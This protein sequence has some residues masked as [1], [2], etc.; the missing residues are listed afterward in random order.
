M[1]WDIFLLKQI[2]YKIQDFKGWEHS[3]VRGI[4]S[5]RSMY[6]CSMDV[7][8][9]G[10]DIEDKNEIHTYYGLLDTVT[11]LRLKWNGLVFPGG[12]SPRYVSDHNCE[13]EDM[14]NAPGLY[15]P[16]FLLKQ[17]W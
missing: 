9:Y 13:K 5:D 15:Y 1:C 14:H 11:V 2:L 6:S 8:K 3:G 4:G 7:P 12:G 16:E 10:V 17:G